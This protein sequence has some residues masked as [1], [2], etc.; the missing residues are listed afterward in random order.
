MEGF[1]KLFQELQ[2]L[3]RSVAESAFRIFDTDNNG[4]LNFR[5]FLSSL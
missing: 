1:V 4:K 5:E 3:P 2:D